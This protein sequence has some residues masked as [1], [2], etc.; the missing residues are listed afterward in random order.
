[1]AMG[2]TSIGSIHSYTVVTWE[3]VWAKVLQLSQLLGIFQSL[4]QFV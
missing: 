2:L 1:M 3:A 4:G